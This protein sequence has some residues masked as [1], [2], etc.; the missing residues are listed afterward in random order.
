[1]VSA[2]VVFVNV[3]MITMETIVEILI[4]PVLPPNVK[5]QIL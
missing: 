3:K 1:V 5:I 4:V 2:L